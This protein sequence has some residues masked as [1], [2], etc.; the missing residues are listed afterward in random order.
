[1]LKQQSD[2]KLYLISKTNLNYNFDGEKLI[3][4][5]NKNTNPD[6]FKV[7][8]ELDYE[9]DEKKYFLLLD[10]KELKEIKIS[11]NK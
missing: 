9:S 3:L 8:A 10:D 1:M 2:K 4:D 5:L 11:P 6:R 7:R